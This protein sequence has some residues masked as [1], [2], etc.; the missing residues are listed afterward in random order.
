MRTLSPQTGVSGGLEGLN[1]WCKHKRLSVI[2]PKNRLNLGLVLSRYPHGLSCFLVSLTVEC[3]KQ[4]FE[5]MHSQ[6]TI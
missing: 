2:L 5:A 6:A 4:N 1:R 3:N